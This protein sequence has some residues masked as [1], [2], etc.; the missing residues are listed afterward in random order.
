[1]STLNRLRHSLP[2]RPSHLT[3]RVFASPDLWS[4]SAAGE[5]GSTL[6]V[7]DGIGLGGTDALVIDAWARRLFAARGDPREV[8]GNPHAH[9]FGAE[10]PAIAA[11]WAQAAGVRWRPS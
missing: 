7:G 5:N 10:R 9:G 3:G 4:G 8:I 11:S 1:M 6:L 2:R